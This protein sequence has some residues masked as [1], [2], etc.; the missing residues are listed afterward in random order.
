MFCSPQSH[1]EGPL[2]M[3]ISSLLFHL[4][5]DFINVYVQDIIIT[6]IWGTGMCIQHIWIIF[7]PSMHPYT[8]H[9]SL[10]PQHP[11]PSP[12]HLPFCFLPHELT[13]YNSTWN[14]LLTPCQGSSGSMSWTW[15]I[16]SYCSSCHSQVKCPAACLLQP[17]HEI[18]SL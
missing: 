10:L 4:L 12:T 8:I 9:P 1:A 15:V 3:L 16:L 5:K 11:S 18:Y 14:L 13:N 2:Q 6:S 17:L 7:N